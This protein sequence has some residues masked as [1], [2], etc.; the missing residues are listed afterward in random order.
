MVT[1]VIKSDPQVPCTDAVREA[2]EVLRGG[3]LVAFPTETVYGLGARAD[4][5]GA[6]ERLRA[7]KSREGGKAFTVHIASR[8]DAKQF[9]PQLTGMA[10]R[11]ARKGWPGPITLILDVEH[12]ESS[13]IM[14]GRNG[15]VAAAI[16][17]DNTIGLRCPDDPLAQG[18]LRT[19]EAPVVAASANPAGEPAP[20]SGEDVLKRL[21]G[22]IDLVVDAGRTK[23][24][25][26][27][28]IVRVTDRSFEVI[29]EGVYDSGSIARLSTVRIL[30]VCSGN[31]CRSP[32][33]AHW[34]RHMLAERLGCRPEDLSDRGVT[35]VS[36]GTSGGIGGASPFAAEVMAKRGVDLSGHT[37]TALNSEM[38][39]QADYVFAM[40]RAH[41]DAILRMSPMSESKVRLLLDDDDVSDPMGGTSEDYERGALTIERGLRARLQEVVV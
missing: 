8:E 3:G 28:T 40:T 22:A 18:M 11:L 10:A 12:P 35:V 14:K 15:A 30:F 26:P 20:L 7:V 6:M 9:V 2:S 39:H 32:M 16:Y 38:I 36:A 34:A 4:H 13:P 17:Y 27:S 23:Y 24:A 37:S 29:R 41:R 25:K 5:P 1:T 19:V 31:T 21:D 33:A